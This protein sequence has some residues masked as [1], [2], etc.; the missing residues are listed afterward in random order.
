MHYTIT[1]INIDID[2][3]WYHHNSEDIES[4]FMRLLSMN[5]RPIQGLLSI[6]LSIYRTTKLST[7]LPMVKMSLAAINF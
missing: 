2:P 7:L 4:G 1:H 6:N 5:S 3:N